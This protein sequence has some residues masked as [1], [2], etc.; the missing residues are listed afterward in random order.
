MEREHNFYMEKEVDEVNMPHSED[1][2]KNMPEIIYV[3]HCA[4]KDAVKSKI[5]LGYPFPE[6][7]MI[8]MITKTT[9]SPYK[10]SLNFTLLVSASRTSNKEE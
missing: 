5:I 1:T 10:R 7:D 9:S 2:E 6:N 3:S 4:E 8:S